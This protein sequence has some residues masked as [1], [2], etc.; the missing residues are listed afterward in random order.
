[1]SGAVKIRKLTAK[2]LPRPLERKWTWELFINTELGIEYET[3]TVDMGLFIAF[4]PIVGS[5]EHGTV[6][7]V[8]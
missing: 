2:K 7:N 8:R 1:M 4:R 3:I 5:A 6:A